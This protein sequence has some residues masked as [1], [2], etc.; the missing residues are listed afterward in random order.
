MLTGK[1][2]LI[3]GSSRGIGAATARLAKS[4]GATVILHGHSESDNL[5]EIAK[6][7]KS[8]YIVCDVSDKDAVEKEIT[9]ILGKGIK[10]NGLVNNAGIVH[11]NSFV[12]ITD[13]EWMQV[14]GVNLLGPIH[15]CRALIPQ[16]QEIGGG[17]IVNLSSIRAHQ[18]GVV[19]GRIVYSTSKAALTSMTYSLA[20]ELGPTIRVNAVSSGAV[21]TDIS[22]TW[23][24]EMREQNKKV[25]LG[26]LGQ[27]ED[28]AEVVCFLL[29]DKSRF[30]T[31]SDY[32][33]DGGF[34]TGRM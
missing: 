18:Q 12:N 9:R 21:D 2:I 7:L 8:E 19:T 22:K 24:P 26:R 15:F 5:K 14:F 34:L 30:V 33:V 23:N 31:G 11:R 13:E 32:A 28:I 10:I 3:T 4:Y 29:S 16:M 17:S 1:T 20:K 25:P 6:E 27:P